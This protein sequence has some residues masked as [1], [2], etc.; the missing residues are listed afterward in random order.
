LN[1]LLKHSN[2]SAYL[3]DEVYWW[4]L[5]PEYLPHFK[6]DDKSEFEMTKE[7]VEK[8]ID[9]KVGSMNINLLCTMAYLNALYPDFCDTHIKLIEKIEK[10]LKD[11][12]IKH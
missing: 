12:G 10:D 4:D 3:K 6:D 5:C 7:E 9:E 1:N 11:N 2:C 8:L